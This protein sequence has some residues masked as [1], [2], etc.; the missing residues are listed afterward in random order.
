MTLGE[1]LNDYYTNRKQKYNEKGFL[2]GERLGQ[3]FV[4]D[5]VKT[6]WPDLF[7]QEDVDKSMESILSYLNYYQYYDCMP[8]KIK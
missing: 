4:N 8:E 5:F 1:W 7:Y 2:Q 3:A 6:P